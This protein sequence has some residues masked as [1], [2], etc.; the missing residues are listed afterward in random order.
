MRSDLTKQTLKLREGEYSLLVG[1]SNIHFS[2][3]FSSNI[4]NL[5]RRRGRL[6]KLLRCRLKI[7]GKLVVSEKQG[8]E[9]DS[10][11][12]RDAGFWRNSCV[13]GVGV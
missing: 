1:K 6:E 11:C 12:Y 4:H 5:R 13:Q 10:S 9:D 7:N 8:E 3:M 2:F